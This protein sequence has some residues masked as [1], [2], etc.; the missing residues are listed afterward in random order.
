MPKPLISGPVR[1]GDRVLM[2]S[3]MSL[4][5]E[6]ALLLQMR[7]AVKLANAPGGFWK[8]S[9]PSLTWLKENKMLDEFKE[10]CQY[11]AALEA[12]QELPAGNYIEL[13]RTTAEGVAIELFGR[14]RNTHPE[15]SL[16]ELKA[17]ITEP[18]A[19]EVHLQMLEAISEK[20]AEGNG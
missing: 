12:H 18:I 5:Q 20:D 7:Q 6:Q 8:T 17:V 4:R 13:F 9:Q 14:T 1:I 15:I 19:F 16:E 11:I 10:S 3:Q 2:V